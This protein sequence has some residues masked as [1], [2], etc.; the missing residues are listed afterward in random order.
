M[1]NSGAIS[2]LVMVQLSSESSDT[3]LSSNDGN[4]LSSNDGKGLLYSL[5]TASTKFL[6]HLRQ[7]QGTIFL[8]CGCAIEVDSSDSSS[9]ILEIAQLL[10]EKRVIVNS[11]SSLSKVEVDFLLRLIL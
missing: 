11:S 8:L 5:I 1:N 10:R 2:C 7:L 9:S 4:E 3:K 6:L